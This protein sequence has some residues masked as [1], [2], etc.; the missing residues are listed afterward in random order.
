MIFKAIARVRLKFKNQKVWYIFHT[1]Y[2]FLPCSNDSL[3]NLLFEY[4]L[5]G[6]N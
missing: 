2:A 5:F 4:S 1:D 3:Q 6:Q